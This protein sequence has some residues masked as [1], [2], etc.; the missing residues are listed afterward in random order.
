MR[1]ILLLSLVLVAVALAGSSAL[2]NAS[3]TALAQ[4]DT[5]QD[6]LVVFESFGRET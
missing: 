6:R 3:G 5:G 1:R 2:H 4:G